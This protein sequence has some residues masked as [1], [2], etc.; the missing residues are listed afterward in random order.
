[1]KRQTDD[2]TCNILEAVWVCLDVGFVVRI[3]RVGVAEVKSCKS[4]K[5]LCAKKSFLIYQ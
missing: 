3:D 4:D 2:L 5:D 1:M